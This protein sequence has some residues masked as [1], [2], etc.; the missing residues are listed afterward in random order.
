[1]HPGVLKEAPDNP[2]ELTTAAWLVTNEACILLDPVAE[3]TSR[4]QG[5]NTAFLS[6]ADSHGAAKCM[7]TGK[8]HF[9]DTI[10]RFVYLM[11]LDNVVFEANV[12]EHESPT[13]H[14]LR[15]T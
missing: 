12:F 10:F 7:R 13:T 5:G 11:A 1:M 3:V 2:P 9:F 15:Q 14:V 6:Q 4:I 8:S